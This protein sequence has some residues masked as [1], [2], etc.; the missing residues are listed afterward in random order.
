MKQDERRS[1]SV[2]PLTP[3]NRSALRQ[4]EVSLRQHANNH[5]TIQGNAATPEQAALEAAEASSASSTQLKPL[6]ELT[7]R[8]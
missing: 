1:S 2:T 4:V 3:G 6:L 7:S 5:Y 8:V